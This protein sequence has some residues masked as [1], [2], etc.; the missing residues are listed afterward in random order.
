MCYKLI[1]INANGEFPMS[2]KTTDIMYSIN[3][4][5]IG[6]RGKIKKDIEN[7]NTMSFGFQN[8]QDAKADALKVIEGRENDLIKANQIDFYDREKFNN[9]PLNVKPFKTLIR[10]I[11]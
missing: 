2:Y 6:Y 10:E 5:A 11:K 1:N 9:D 8:V 4:L 3:W 7:K